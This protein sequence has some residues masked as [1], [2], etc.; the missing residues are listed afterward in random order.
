MVAACAKAQEEEDFVQ[1]ARRIPAP[2]SQEEQDGGNDGDVEDVDPGHVGSDALDEPGSVVEENE[3]TDREEGEI[4]P[5]GRVGALEADE[6]E[7]GD[8]EGEV[9]EGEDHMGVKSG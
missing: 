8:D 9:E 2:P 6:E 3:D 5:A 7:E 4:D 1:P